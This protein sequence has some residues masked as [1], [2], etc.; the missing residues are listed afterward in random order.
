M[1]GTERLI[2]TL[3]SRGIRVTPQRAIILAAIEQMARADQFGGVVGHGT[4][5]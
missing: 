4:Q 3:K 5:P 2:D 1:A